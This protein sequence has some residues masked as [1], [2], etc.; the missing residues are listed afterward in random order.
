[1]ACRGAGQARFPAAASVNDP[2][3]VVGGV[4]LLG[5]QHRRRRLLP[6]AGC[7]MVGKLDSCGFERALQEN[8]N[9]TRHGPLAFEI[10]NGCHFDTGGRCQPILASIEKPASSTRL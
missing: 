6:H 9:A 5:P 1:M 2:S 8:R 10:A 7:A 3:L 4:E